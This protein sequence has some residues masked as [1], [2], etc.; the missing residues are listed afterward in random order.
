VH[1]G[2][3]ARVLGPLGSWRRAPT[4][5][6]DLSQRKRPRYL[7]AL[8]TLKVFPARTPAPEEAPPPFAPASSSLRKERVLLRCR[9]ADWENASMY[10][11]IASGQ[12]GV[13]PVGHRRLSFPPQLEWHF[14]RRTDCNRR[15]SHPRLR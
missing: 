7:S 10:D 3:G 4:G 11:T 5:Q 6:D 2:P 1:W 15:R 9:A 13:A 8:G 12:T 14:A